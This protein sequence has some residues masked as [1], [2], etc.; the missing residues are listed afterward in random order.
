MPTPVKD[1]HQME[2]KADNAEGEGVTLP[3]YDNGTKPYLKIYRDY[4]FLVDFPRDLKSI[5]PFEV[6]E[7]D[8]WISTFP[9]SGTTWVQEIVYLVMNNADTGKA[10]QT[11]IER[12]VP[13]FEYP[14][15]GFKAISAMPSP[16]L[17]KSHLP[18]SLLPDQMK[19]KKPKIIY[20]YRNPK[21]TVVSYYE[22]L[23]KF[24]TYTKFTGK[25]EDFCRLF[26]EGKVLCGP[27]W[28][29]VTEAWARRHEDNFLLLCYEDLQADLDKNV[30]IVAEF[31]GKS[32]TD[33]QVARI[34]KHC[35]FDSM[36]NNNTVNYEWFKRKGLARKEP[37]FLRNGKVG[38]WKNHLSPDIV[39]QFDEIVATKLP[40]DFP[41]KDTLSKL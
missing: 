22:F 15:P 10:L 36:K 2:K 21:D 40:M 34:V 27:W 17:I 14:I 25:F 7:D 26:T 24:L 23:V 4:F 32:L 30:R 19:A 37:K 13:F 11:T 29:H 1:S 31:L 6:R 18:L 35:S 33:E 8:I 41:I 28:K 3:E 38:D 39:K 5:P 9:K 16:R 12:R 20:V